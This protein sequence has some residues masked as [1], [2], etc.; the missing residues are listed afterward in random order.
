MSHAAVLERSGEDFSEKRKCF[1]LESFRKAEI[2][3]GNLR[4]SNDV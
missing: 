3:K 1:D 2:I 4:A